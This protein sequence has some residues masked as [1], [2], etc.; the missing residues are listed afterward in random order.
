MQ[1]LTITSNK[2]N[3]FFLEEVDR[4]SNVSAL[5][6]LWTGIPKV[7]KRFSPRTIKTFLGKGL[8]MLPKLL[9]SI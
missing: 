8:I 4:E 6:M 7:G 2:I 1:L 3:L 5:F 9:E